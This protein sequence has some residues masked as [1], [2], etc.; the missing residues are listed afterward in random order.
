MST[1]YLLLKESKEEL[2]NEISTFFNHVIDLMKKTI[3]FIETDKTISNDALNEIVLLEEKSDFLYD[4]VLN[5]SI[6]IIQKD[7]PRAQY[8]RFVISCINSAKELERASDYIQNIAKFLNKTKLDK[9]IIN[10]FLISFNKS[11]DI[12]ETSYKLFIENDLSATKKEIKE[13]LIKYDIFYKEHM[14]K[15]IFS[16]GS[17][18]M[19]EEE[20]NVLIDL[21]IA[22]SNL[23]RIATHI[24]NVIKAFSYINLK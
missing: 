23:E 24:Y 8:L 17:I 21:T 18:K 22:F 6:W 10:E 7:Q 1:N 2:L 4:D 3:S 19:T 16:F 11:V 9:K 14:R 15:T 13:L 12:C 5:S 20:N